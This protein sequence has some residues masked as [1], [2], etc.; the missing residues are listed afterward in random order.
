MALAN[1]SARG[2][3]VPIVSFRY[4]QHHAARTLRADQRRHGELV[5]ALRTRHARLFAE[6]RVSRPRSSARATVKLAFTLID[7]APLIPTHRKAQ[8]LSLASYALEP[9]MRS[10]SPPGGAALRRARGAAGAQIRR[11]LRALSRRQ[12]RRH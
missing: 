4:R 12:G 9:E 3:R 1:V 10:G 6:R 2:V 7:A 11:M 8:A 5:R